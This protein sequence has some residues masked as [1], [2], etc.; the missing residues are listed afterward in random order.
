MC[1]KNLHTWK[2]ILINRILKK[3]SEIICKISNL[4]A[5]FFLSTSFRSRASCP[6]SWPLSS[7]YPYPDR[8]RVLLSTT[9]PLLIS[10]SESG[11]AMW[12]L[13]LSWHSPSPCPYPVWPR[14]FAPL[15]LPPS[16]PLLIRSGRMTPVHNR[17]PGTATKRSLT[18][19]LCH[20]T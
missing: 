19:R 1:A 2:G 10:L 16:S 11:L 13:Y 15:S 4:T 20:S 9:W 6:P 12:L 18:Q 17:N 5:L 14:Y 7:P 8:W 3:L